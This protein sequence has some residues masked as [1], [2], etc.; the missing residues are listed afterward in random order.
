MLALLIMLSF[1]GNDEAEHERQWGAM[2]GKY[3]SGMDL[4]RFTEPTEFGELI[5][6]RWKRKAAAFR[7]SWPQK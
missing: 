5:C 6:A 7:Q 3:L 1:T 4:W 2:Q